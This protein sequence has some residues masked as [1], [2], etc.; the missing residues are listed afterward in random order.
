MENIFDSWLVNKYVA[1]R[2]LHDEAHPENSLSAFKNAIENDYTIELD[3]HQIEDGTIVVFHDETLMRMT[4]QDG[5]VN[6]IKTA[7]DLK[8]YKLSNT[9]ETIPTLQEVLN[10]VKGKVP[11]LIEIKNYKTQQYNPG[12]P[13]ENTLYEMLKNYKGDYAIMSFN[14]YVL[15]W[16]RI[17]APEVLRGQLSSFFKGERLKGIVKF[18]LKHMLLN[19]KVSKPD[20]IAYN[21]KNLPNRFVKKYKKLPL[22][23]WAVPSQQEY[24]KVAPH[25]DNIIFEGFTPR[26]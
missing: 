20:F 7:G 8:K 15:K 23:A 1:H 18:S 26:I 14:P 22:L 17:H 5:Y 25:C 6:Q 16:F 10:L 21:Y 4:G 11:I 24:M 9:E 2:G 3:V 13:L 19:K 12:N